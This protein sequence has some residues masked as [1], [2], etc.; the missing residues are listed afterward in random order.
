MH[1]FWCQV[2]KSCSD[3]VRHRSL[4]IEFPLHVHKCLSYARHIAK[5]CLGICERPIS[6]RQK[7]AQ[8]THG[9]LSLAHRPAGARASSRLPKPRRR[10][11]LLLHG[12]DLKTM[13]YGVYSGAV[14]DDN[15]EHLIDDVVVRKLCIADKFHSSS[16]IEISPSLIILVAR[17]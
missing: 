2:L 12:H 3:P 1:F 5:R 16:S 11:A 17:V 6:S 4:P 10:C 7:F 8:L 15:G 9:Q 14:R 13:S